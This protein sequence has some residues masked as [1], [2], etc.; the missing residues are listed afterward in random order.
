M[1]RQHVRNHPP[2]PAKPEDDRLA[3]SRAKVIIFDVVLA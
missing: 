2:D 1:F 3:G